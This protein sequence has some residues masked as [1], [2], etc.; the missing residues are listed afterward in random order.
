MAAAFLKEA[1]KHELPVDGVRAESGLPEQLLP[2][3]G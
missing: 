1:R 2:C 3:A